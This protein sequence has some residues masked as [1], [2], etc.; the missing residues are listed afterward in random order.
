MPT[1]TVAPP[2]RPV[3]LPTDERRL[4]IFDLDRTLLPGS[5]LVPLGRAMV[6]AGIV[7]SSDL[8][9]LA[10]GEIRFRRRG[11]SEAGTDRLRERLLNLA[12][13][14]DHARLV[15]VADGVGIEVAN[16]IGP[17]ARRLIGRH[18][19]VGDQV[20]VLSSSPQE[21]VEQVAHRLGAH[22]GVGTRTEVLDGVL[23]GRLDGPFCYREG[24]L[25]RLRDDVGV[26][27]LAT[28]FA[29]SD[30]G[31]DLPLLSACGYPAAV[32]P[33]RRLRAAARAEGW[34][35]IELF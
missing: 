3:P 18:L 26:S 11:V 16:L 24:K 4:A 1:T 14:K 35:I 29:Y 22:R 20:V 30:A 2:T 7:R 32:N 5:S 19:D 21:L 28:S 27:D 6:G 23:T 15:E 31:S 13:G 8:S 10:V 25:A 34:P 9:R 17:A 33:D 12:A